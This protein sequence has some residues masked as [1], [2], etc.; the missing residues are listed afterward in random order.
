MA[1]WAL[2]LM[3]TVLFYGLA[4]ALTKQLMAN[5]TSSAF[6][7][8]YIICK[9]AINVGAYLLLSQH[10]VLDPGVRLFF[11]WAILAN[12]FNA[13]AWLFYYKALERGPV[14]IVGTVV[15]AF[16][17]VTVILS[18]PILGEKLAVYQYIGVALAILGGILVSY[19][20]ETEAMPVAGRGSGWL[21]SA[22]LVFLLWGI[23]M[24]VIKLAYTKPNYDDYVFLIG[25]AAMITLILAPYGL[26]TLEGG[27]GPRR[28]VLL[29]LIPTTLFC[30]GD[31][32]LFWAVARGPA[33]IVT[34]LQ[35]AYPLVTILYA[36]AFMK[37]RM[38]AYQQ[39]GLGF[40]LGAILLIS[41]VPDSQ[42][43][44]PL[45]ILAFAL[46]CIAVGSLLLLR[47][48]LRHPSPSTSQAAPPLRDE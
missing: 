43:K 3:A 39:G 47:W 8:L 18:W 5:I 34:P 38:L 31:V 46:G 44:L 45:A 27:L 2:P 17:V 20:R 30:L 32:A 35:G 42:G 11:L 16:P 22:L 10:S 9:L 24:V 40:I 1:S 13:L 14:S 48:L 21:V 6:I 37:E 12:V 7:L 25:N 29:A 36:A 19:Q 23:T 41:M 15:A 33:S 28:D 26:F 4:Q